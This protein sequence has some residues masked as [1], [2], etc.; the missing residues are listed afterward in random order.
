VSDRTSFLARR[1]TG[2]G[3]SDVGAIVGVDPY[4]NA[5]DV[6][7]E[8]TGELPDTPATRVQER[9]R[10]LEPIIREMYFERSGR[11]Q[12]QARFRRHPKHKW[13]LGHPDSLIRGT[14]HPEPEELD[15]FE[16]PGVLECKSMNYAILKKTEDRGLSET[17]QL[18]GQHYCKLCGHDWVAFA[19]LHPDSWRFAVINLEADAGVQKQMI[20]IC[21][22]F[23][24]NHVVP[25]Q[26]PKPKDPEWEIELPAVEGIVVDRHD[27]P[28]RTALGQ[29]QA[30]K[31]LLAEAKEL[32]DDSR[33]AIKEL[34]E[35]HGVFEGAGARVYFKQR[36]G[37]KRL[38]RKVIEAAGLIDPLKLAVWAAEVEEEYPGII[39]LLQAEAAGL[40]AEIDGLL[41][42]G[43][44]YEDLRIFHV[45]ED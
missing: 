21:E 25:R 44:P 11:R 9:G 19:L 30:M 38:N 23:W 15:V 13:L 16:R 41:T 6:Y 4:R 28:W 2:I 26:P 7:L 37:A 3:G 35:R 27:E 1:K 24:H 31:A 33:G 22:H 20:D 29:E 14:E 43:K 32:Y 17:Y 10:R 8:K 18:Q 36:A 34:C 5:L 40:R 12:K 45:L 39:T 42:E